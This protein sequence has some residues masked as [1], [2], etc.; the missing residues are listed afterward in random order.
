MWHCHVAL[1]CGT[2]TWHCHVVLSCGTV[3]WHRH[4]ALSRGTVTWHCHVTLSCDTV[5]WHCHVALS[6]GTVM[7]HCHVALSS[8]RLSQ[9]KMIYHYLVKVNFEATLSC[10][11]DLDTSV[12][13]ADGKTTWPCAVSRRCWRPG[14]SRQLLMLTA[15]RMRR[16]GVEREERLV[17][18]TPVIPQN[19]LPWVRVRV[20]KK[21]FFGFPLKLNQYQVVNF[22]LC[23]IFELKN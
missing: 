3:M 16:R 21:G 22:S 19:I 4:V 10:R 1:S 23:K 7:W 5:M 14:W 15:S 6:R 12:E 17:S 2:V 11:H 8:S 18:R 9:S 13:I 20:N